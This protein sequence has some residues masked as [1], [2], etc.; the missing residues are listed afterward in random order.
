MFLTSLP[1]SLLP[2]FL[3]LLLSLQH[4][5]WK[6][7]HHQK[8]RHPSTQ[9][10]PL[11]HSPFSL[12]SHFSYSLALCSQLFHHAKLLNLCPATFHSHYHLYSHVFSSLKNNKIVIGFGLCTKSFLVRIVRGCEVVRTRKFLKRRFRSWLVEV[13]KDSAKSSSNIQ[14]LGEVREGIY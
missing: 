7:R 5:P 14:L 12:G 4:L 10:V 9:K 2:L 3:L 1:L 11:I 6:E 13:Y 8:A